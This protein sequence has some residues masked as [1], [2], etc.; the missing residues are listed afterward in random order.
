MFGMMKYADS[1]RNA[2]FAIGATILQADDF[3]EPEHK[4]DH[5]DIR[6][7]FPGAGV[8][9]SFS[10][11]TS[12]NS[13]SYSGTG[14]SV[15]VVNISNSG[16]TTTA[17]IAVG[18]TKGIS[19]YNDLLPGMLEVFGNFPN[20]FNPNTVI[21]FE[22]LEYS[23]VKL[24]VFSITGQKTMQLADGNLGPGIYSVTWNGKDDNGKEVGSGVYFF[25]LSVDGR[26]V[27]RKMLRLS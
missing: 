19:A 3:W 13:N 16:A 2:V 21:R 23:R 17:D 14:T 1:Y 22:I 8:N 24:E 6:D 15:A 25:K 18:T 20:P 9:R 12:P 10:G 7:F 27:S 5:A 11:V 26:S 4:T